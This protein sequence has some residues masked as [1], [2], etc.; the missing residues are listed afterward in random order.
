VYRAAVCVEPVGDREEI[1]VRI[2]QR[3]LNHHFRAVTLNMFTSSGGISAEVTR[4]TWMPQTAPEPSLLYN[5]RA[6][7]ILGCF[8]FRLWLRRDASP[9]I[10]ALGI[11]SLVGFAVALTRVD[12]PFAGRAADAAE[13]PACRRPSQDRM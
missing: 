6:P 2:V 5:R 10:A 4:V 8:T 11:V 7:R 9:A 1:S 13:T 3:L 12:A